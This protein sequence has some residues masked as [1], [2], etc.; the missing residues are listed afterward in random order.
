V[1]ARLSYVGRILS[2]LLLAAALVGV[3]AM[4]VTSCAPAPRPGPQ[5]IAPAQPPAVTADC[6]APGWEDAARTNANSLSGLYWTPFGR[7]EVGWRIYAPLI[8]REIGVNCP[9]QSQA[10]AQALAAWQTREGMTPDGLVSQATFIH[11]KG[12]LQ[13]RRPI[14]LLSVEGFCAAPAVETK[15]AA[16]REDE[17]L[18]DK[19]V[20]LRPGALAAYR[21]MVAAA[22]ADEPAIAADPDLLKI[23]SGYRSPDYDAARCAAENNCNGRERATCSP[24][25]TGLAM[26]LYLGHAPG[27]TADSTADENR[28]TMT[29]SA[30]YRWLLAN[31][32][33]FGFVNYPFE[34][35][36][37]EWTGE[38]PKPGPPPA[39]IAV[40]AAGSPLRS[41][42]SAGP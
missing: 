19:P 1:D 2:G 21:R 12:L 8:A 37:W 5:A 25:R 10:F 24:H 17:K 23:F 28:L 39:Q 3:V 29:E 15:L 6:R 30:A 40:S 31:A 41:G 35:W 32:G 36:H 7:D 34:P 38:A 14:V 27:F 18:G 9:P 13:S 11:L 20:L 16:L 42:Q 33:R 4:R 26:D 22:R